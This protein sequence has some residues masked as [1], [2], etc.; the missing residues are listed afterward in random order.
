MAALG[1]ADPHSPQLLVRWLCNGPHTGWPLPAADAEP[2]SPQLVVRWVRSG[3]CGAKGLQLPA[4]PCSAAGAAAY[5]AHDDVL[6]LRQAAPDCPRRAGGGGGREPPAELRRRGEASCSL[7][8]AAAR[9]TASAN[10]SCVTDR[11][12]CCKLAPLAALLLLLRRGAMPPLALPD[13]AR[14]APSELGAAPL[15]LCRCTAAKP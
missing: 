12:E 10:A 15:L 3:A 13:S 11:G 14:L 6:E 4:S 2:Q 9:L 1:G 7:A 8:W 5:S